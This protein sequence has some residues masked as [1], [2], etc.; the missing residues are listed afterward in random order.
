MGLALGIITD[1]LLKIVKLVFGTDKPMVTEVVHAKPEIP[2]ASRP[3]SDLLS[4]CG[5]KLS[6]AEHFGENR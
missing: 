4:E 6:I 2:I 5:V 1:I 3:D